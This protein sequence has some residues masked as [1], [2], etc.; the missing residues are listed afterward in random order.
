MLLKLFKSEQKKLIN[1]L[2]REKNIVFNR[3]N[4]S[5]TIFSEVA[6]VDYT[7]IFIIL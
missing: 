3:E 4:S 7:H 6:K 5:N 1:Q 2:L